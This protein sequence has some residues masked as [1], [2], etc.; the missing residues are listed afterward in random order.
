M[1]IAVGRNHDRT[2]M[3]YIVSLILTHSLTFFF[4][5]FCDGDD[6]FSLPRPNDCEERKRVASHFCGWASELPSG[7]LLALVHLP[8]P[9]QLKFFFNF[10]IF[11]FLRGTSL[12]LL[13]QSRCQCRQHGW[14]LSRQLEGCKACQV[15]DAS[16]RIQS[17]ASGLRSEHSQIPHRDRL[18][19]G[20][21]VTCSAAYQK[22]VTRPTWY[23]SFEDDSVV[24]VSSWEMLWGK[25]GRQMV[26]N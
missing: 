14:W 25:C 20:R 4:F 1:G 19:L 2:S 5:F 12:A 15:W 9:V 24:Q 21:A 3:S 6:L 11:F 10:L 8:V 16:S 18:Q 7:S 13:M 26:H 23:D 22:L 17:I